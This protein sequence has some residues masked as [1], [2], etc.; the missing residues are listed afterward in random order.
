MAAPSAPALCTPPPTGAAATG[1]M[2]VH[3]L[4]TCP[5][6]APQTSGEGRGP[7]GA[8]GGDGGRDAVEER[9]KC[10]WGVQTPKACA[11]KRWPVP[12]VTAL[13]P[14]YEMCVGGEGGGGCVCAIE[15]EGVRR[16]VLPG[17]R[18][19]APFEGGVLRRGWGAHAGLR[20]ALRMHVRVRTRSNG[21]RCVLHSPVSTATS[22]DVCTARRTAPTLHLHFAAS[23][24]PQ[25]LA[26]HL[27]YTGGGGGI[28]PLRFDTPGGGGLGWVG[29]RP[30]PKAVCRDP[31]SVCL[32]PQPPRLLTIP[33]PHQGAGEREMPPCLCVSVARAPGGRGGVVRHPLR[34]V[35]A[36]QWHRW[37]VP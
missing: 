22:A 20:G 37:S 3:L 25:P 18:T 26:R 27:R 34:R 6:T 31:P 4:G 21:R 12:P 9:G 24:R 23:C 7:G 2:C 8:G 5:D 17:V 13:L 33:D 14:R 30:A 1:P 35:S 28:R 19:C 15:A 16:R 32:V 36:A 29:S 11:P 10:G